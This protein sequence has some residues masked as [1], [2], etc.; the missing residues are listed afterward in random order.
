MGHFFLNLSFIL[1][2]ILYIPQ[3]IHNSKNTTFSHMSR[4]MHYMLLQAYCCDFF[5]SI[6]R[7]MPWQYLT[8]SC[9]G[10]FYLLIQHIQWAHFDIKTEGHLHKGM[11]TIGVIILTWPALLWMFFKDALWQNQLQIW[12]SKILFIIHFLPQII[13]NSFSRDHIHAISKNYLALSVI[14]SL[15]DFGAAYCLRWDTANLTGSSLSLVFKLML[16]VQMLNY[17]RFKP[18]LSFLKTRSAL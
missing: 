8:V 16:I 18:R 5:Y 9:L 4:I 11:L 17:S 10:T 6:S 13:K 14:L 1:Y 2:L 12:L 15:T 3:L 7:G